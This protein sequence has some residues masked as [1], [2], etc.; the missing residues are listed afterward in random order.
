MCAYH[1]RTTSKLPYESRP[2][3][4]QIRLLQAG[5]RTGQDRTATQESGFWVI[6][7]KSKPPDGLQ[8]DSK[9]ESER[10]VKF[11]LEFNQ[12]IS[13]S[14]PHFS[15]RFSSSPLFSSFLLHPLVDTP[16]LYAL[17]PSSLDNPSSFNHTSIPVTS[18]HLR[19]PSPA[20]PFLLLSRTPL[21]DTPSY[22]SHRNHIQRSNHAWF[23]FVH[24]TVD[25]FA[26]VAGGSLAHAHSPTGPRLWIQ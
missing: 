22:R 20:L 14:R 12:L 23:I 16:S 10:S 11:G 18:H 25:R 19:Q 26:R 7:W 15:K 9:R 3:L 24:P 2:S 6:G 5:Q 8:P 21:K 4:L 17:S 1:T 13:K